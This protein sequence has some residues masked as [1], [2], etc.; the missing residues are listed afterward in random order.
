VQ[1]TVIIV[2]YNEEENISAC[3]DSVLQQTIDSSNYEVI[4]VDNNST[5]GTKKII[6]GYINNKCSNIILYINP[7]RGIAGSRLIGVEKAKYDYIAFTDADCIVPSNWL[8]TLQAGFERYSVT[9][10]SL[11]GVGGANL[12][13]QTSPFYEALGI[14]LNTFWGSHGSAQG[15]RFREDTYVSHIPTVNVLYKKQT[16]IDIENFDKSFGNICEDVDLNHR[17]TQKGYRLMFLKD[18]YVEHNMR[19]SFSSW[20][21]N[22]FTY[23][24]GRVWVIKKHFNHLKFMY[25][26]PIVFVLA[27]GISPLGFFNPYF[28]LGLWYFPI[29]TIISL[30]ETIKVKKIKIFPYVLTIYIITHIAYGVGEIYGLFSHRG[31]Q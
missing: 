19:S 1:I 30:L 28:A 25:L 18:C 31:N 21:K 14:I 7:V 2:C 26:V 23:G 11:A 15:K 17:L 29:I 10:K 12:P 5:D 22:M 9:D 20:W 6:K 13:P 8:Q 16:V 24:K 3:L 27:L 4:V